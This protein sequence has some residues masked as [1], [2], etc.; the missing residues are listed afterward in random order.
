[1]SVQGVAVSIQVAP[2]GSLLDYRLDPRVNNY[3]TAEML[4]FV[5]LPIT[6]VLGFPLSMATVPT[7]GPRIRNIFS[8]CFSRDPDPKSPT[9]G[10]PLIDSATD[11]AV[12][13]V[14][15]DGRYLKMAQVVAM[16][17]M[18][19]E[20]QT[21][22]TGVKDREA[23]GEVV[24]REE[25]AARLLTPASFVRFFGFLKVAALQNGETWWKRVECP[26]RVAGI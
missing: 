12:L 11:E 22:V 10:Q 17:F 9:F 2:P 18:L 1:M 4:K 20:A 16:M 6:D 25:I 15:R 21:E 26:V 24:D 13:L 5:E 3:A 19:R 14:R 23:A 7:P 8:D